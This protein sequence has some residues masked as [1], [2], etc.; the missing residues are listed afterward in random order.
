[1]ASNIHSMDI[2]FPTLYFT[3]FYKI[4]WDVVLVTVHI[5][6][7]TFFT[8]ANWRIG[9]LGA[10]SHALRL[11]QRRQSGD[12]RVSKQGAEAVRLLAFR[13]VE[14]VVL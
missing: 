1:M 14:K 9:S 12:R 3:G 2:P 4:K 5:L 10:G 6:S 7:A 8:H 13:I 11:E